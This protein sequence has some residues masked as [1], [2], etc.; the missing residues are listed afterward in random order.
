MGSRQPRMKR[1]KCGTLER[2]LRSIRTRTLFEA[3]NCSCLSSRSSALPLIAVAGHVAQAWALRLAALRARC[4]ACRVEA[5]RGRRRR[6]RAVESDASS[7]LP[8]ARARAFGARA[9]TFWAG[10]AAASSRAALGTAWTSPWSGCDPSVCSG[11]Q[12]GILGC[13][14]P[15]KFGR[16]FSTLTVPVFVF[17]YSTLLSSF[18]WCQ[19][20]LSFFTQIKSSRPSFGNMSYS[21]CA[22]LSYRN[23]SGLALPP[24]RIT[25]FFR[26]GWQQ[27]CDD[28]SNF[29]QN[30]L[31]RVLTAHSA[32]AYDCRD[33]EPCSQFSAAK[34]RTKP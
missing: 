8:R 30:F 12:L 1:H 16:R 24:C 27:L 17:P 19:I 25:A 31:P 7:E 15:R 18:C 9:G 22:A 21:L 6:R 13:L 34:T 20:L 4:V 33:V 32:I 28:L 26:G 10:S 11:T 5:E 23:G 3:N 14:V 29:R 2:L